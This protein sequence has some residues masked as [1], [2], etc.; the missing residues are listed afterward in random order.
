MGT[1]FVLY[2]AETR[3][4]LLLY[5]LGLLRFCTYKFGTGLVLVLYRFGTGLVSVLYKF[6]L[7]FW[8][9]EVLTVWDVFHIEYYT[10][11]GSV[12]QVKGTLQMYLRSFE[13]EGKP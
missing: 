3:L 11:F 1:F 6:V 4:D 2:V 9:S 7:E 8:S 12:C 10:G 13:V 5:S